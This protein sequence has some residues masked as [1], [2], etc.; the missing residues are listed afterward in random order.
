[1]IEP[2][3]LP[4]PE[5]VRAYLPDYRPERFLDVDKPI[6]MGPVGIPEIYTESKMAQDVALRESYGPIV[7]AWKELEKVFGRHYEPFVTHGTEDADVVFVVAGGLAE[8]TRTVVDELRAEGKKVG[9]ASLKLWRP[10]P[11][12]DFRKLASQAK[13]LAVVD[14]C[15]S[16]GGPYGPMASEFKAAL[17][18][19]KDRP[20]IV[21]FVAGL[22]G[23]DV[24][25]QDI[26]SMYEDAERVL[27]S[28][29]VPTP[30][31]VGLR[32]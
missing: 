30:R 19:E 32:E 10:F 1:V 13:V 26:R 6:S 16:F 20:P 29:K 5:Q 17:Y 24:P 22:G 18:D 23:R 9:V 14:R 7:E 3:T 2:I 12:D 27:K 28:G 15:I 4:D 11:F 25:K 8:T 31:I 21:E